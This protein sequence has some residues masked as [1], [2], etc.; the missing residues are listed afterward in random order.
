MELLEPKKQPPKKPPNPFFRF[1][2]FLTTVALVL[3]AVFLVANRDTF[4]LDGLRR[5][6]SYRSLSRSD[7]G[8]AESFQYDGGS[9]SSFATLNGGLL[10]CS[11]NSIR[12]YGGNGTV[13]LN[14]TVSMEHPVV[15]S[16]ENA[17]LV[18]DAG[19]TDL[20]LVSDT[21]SVFRLSLEEGSSILSSR[22]NDDGWM[23]VT[24][25]E[26]GYKGV[27]T[28]YNP[29]QE[30]ELRI[31][32]S[33]RFITD[34]VLS[35]DHQTVALVSVGV[36]NASYE[37]RLDFYRLNR[38][39]E[40]TEPD[41]TCS[42]GDQVVLDLRW[43]DDGIWALGDNALF[44]VG[45]NGDLDAT[46]G[47]SGR[48]LKGYSLAGDG[49]AVLL[50]GKYRAGTEAEL[51]VIDPDGTVSSSLAINEQV[52]GLSAAGRYIAVLSSGALN[53][54]TPSLEVYRTLETTQGARQV[55]QRADG[56]TMLINANTAHLYVPN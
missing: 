14:E 47:F 50:L 34:A 4:N 49:Y 7:T 39:T 12:L 26:S 42:L 28:V 21:E 19:G 15:V 31:N 24:A 53:I 6:F 33:S 9:S 55:L 46:Y 18:Y 40:D 1:L 56:S 3:G 13:Y 8:Q 25:Q 52:F 22:L 54:Y 10:V 32:L 43:T 29:Q 20:C 48:Y 30:P 5:W 16:T 23:A 44:L 11:P 51:N 37:S 38:D 41:F 27:V 36:S 45:N 35:S 2:A 17:A